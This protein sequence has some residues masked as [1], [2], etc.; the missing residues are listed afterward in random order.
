MTRGQ[1]TLLMDLDDTP[2]HHAVQL[3]GGAAVPLVVVRASEEELAEHERVLGEVAKESKG[4][5]L[6]LAEPAAPAGA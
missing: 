3:A 1:D 5:C 4:K 6:W 2:A